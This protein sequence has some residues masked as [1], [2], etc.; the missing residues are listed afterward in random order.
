MT[1]GALLELCGARGIAVGA[2]AKK[3]ALV[4]LIL[5]GGA[6]GAEAA[7]T[8]PEEAGLRAMSVQQ[9]CERGRSM[10][11]AVG[12]HTSYSKDELVSSILARRPPVARASGRR[13]QAEGGGA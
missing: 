11:L 6:P 9:L 10:G 3:F 2:N 7:G 12:H 13:R 5:A 1:R 8:A 4:S